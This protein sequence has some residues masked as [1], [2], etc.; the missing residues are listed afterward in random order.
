MEKG[1]LHVFTRSLPYSPA[2]I[3]TVEEAV[4]GDQV[5][6]NMPAELSDCVFRYSNTET[7]VLF[8]SPTRHKMFYNQ[9]SILS[10]G[11]FSARVL[12]TLSGW[13][14]IFFSKDWRRS[15]LSP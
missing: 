6:Y 2:E 15:G 10:S 12:S 1:L 14:K 4:D 3:L 11:D 13:C 5:L 8:E 7:L 9:A